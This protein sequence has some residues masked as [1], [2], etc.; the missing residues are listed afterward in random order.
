[1]FSE[2]FRERLRLGK[3]SRWAVNLTESQ[4]E[5]ILWMVGEFGYRAYWVLP[6]LAG[7]WGQEGSGRAAHALEALFRV[8]GGD[9]PGLEDWRGRVQGFLA[10]V[11]GY[12][13]G[14]GRPPAHS[15]PV[16]WQGKLV[17]WLAEPALDEYGNCSGAWQP[18]GAAGAAFLEQVAQPP[19][20]GVRVT[21]GG[22]PSWVMATPDAAGRIGFFLYVNPHA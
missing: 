10:E 2:E 16:E 8:V 12:A 5:A 18:E 3:Y 20:E 6:L 9:R 21:V 7:L 4:L 13:E 14:E 19:A 1:M 17:G 22:V 11:R 15:W